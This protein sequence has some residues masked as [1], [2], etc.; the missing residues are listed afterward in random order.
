MNN[1]IEQTIYIAADTSKGC[2]KVDFD[3]DIEVVSQRYFFYNLP[4][5]DDGELMVTCFDSSNMHILE[6]IID[7]YGVSGLWAIQTI[8]NLSLQ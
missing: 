2:Y 6:E 7:Q 8:K 3:K 5:L 4:F 1:Q